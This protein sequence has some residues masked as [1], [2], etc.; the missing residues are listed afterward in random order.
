MTCSENKDDCPL[1]MNGFQATFA[2][3]DFIESLNKTL[4]SKLLRINHFEKHSTFPSDLL[5]PCL[6]LLFLDFKFA[7]SLQQLI[8]ETKQETL[9]VMLQDSS[10][11]K[12]RELLHRYLANKFVDGE[13]YVRHVST[14]LVDASCSELTT[15]QEDID[16]I[17]R[18]GKKIRS[19]E[20]S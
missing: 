14:F 2:S 9:C 16:R 13:R 12:A 4:I 15:F 3:Q 17:F 11:H 1:L 10:F 18:S 7:F 6:E 19:E 5:S 8:R 20:I